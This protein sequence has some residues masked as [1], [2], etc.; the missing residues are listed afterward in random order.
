MRQSF[1]AFNMFTLNMWKAVAILQ[2]E[3]V[4]NSFYSPDISLLNFSKLLKRAALLNESKFNKRKIGVVMSLEVSL[5]YK[6]YF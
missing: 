2:M 6:T 3:D 1:S 4:I 5:K